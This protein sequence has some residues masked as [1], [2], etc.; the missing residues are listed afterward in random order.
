RG[1]HRHQGRGADLADRRQGGSPPEQDRCR[2]C[3]GQGGSLRPCGREWGAAAAVEI[4]LAMAKVSRYA[5]AESGDSVEIVER[6]RGGVSV[7]IVDGQRYGEAAKRV[8]HQVANRVVSLIGDGARDGAVI[9]AV[10]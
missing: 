2:L 5:V 4:R 3:Q 7:V 1:D 6:P 8:S 10:H 9:R